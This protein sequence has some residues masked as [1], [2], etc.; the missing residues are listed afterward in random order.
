[1]SFVIYLRKRK[2]HL[3]TDKH[4]YFALIYCNKKK[5]HQQISRLESSGYESITF[6]KFPLLAG[7]PTV[8][9]SF[10][11]SFIKGQIVL[12]FLAKGDDGKV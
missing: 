2:K 12:Y 4:Q 10:W 3:A 5:R 6:S 9:L 1:M 11:F 8:S 7:H